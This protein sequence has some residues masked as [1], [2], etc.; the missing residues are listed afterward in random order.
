MRRHGQGGHTLE[1]KQPRGGDG[2]N[3]DVA[4]SVLGA[5]SRI[6][7]IRRT[8]ARLGPRSSFRGGLASMVRGP[9]VR[10][11]AVSLAA[12]AH[13]LGSARAIHRNQNCAEGSRLE[14]DHDG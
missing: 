5:P 1:R 9:L 7:L 4:V 3:F 10:M 11:L 13:A 2:E 12:P 14:G 6:P 8:A